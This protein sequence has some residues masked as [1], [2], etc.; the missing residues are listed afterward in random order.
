MA[1]LPPAVSERGQTAAHAKPAPASPACAGL[2]RPRP[3]RLPAKPT[4]ICTAG[5]TDSNY[6]AMRMDEEFGIPAPPG[7]SDGIIEL[8]GRGRIS[9]RQVPGPDGAPTLVLL[10]GLAAT[11]RLNWF[12][13]LPALSERY[14]VIVVDHRGHGGG[15]RTRRFRLA[16]CADDVAALADVLEVE[17]YFAVGYSMGG[18]IAKLCW[19][20]HPDRVR[21]LVLCAT[22]R[23]FVWPEARAAASAVMPGMVLAARVAPKTFQRRMMGNVLAGLPRGDR[24]ERVRAELQG[25]DPATVLQAARAVMRFT[26]HDWCSA[27][28]IPT[29]V[30]VTTRDRIVPTSRQYKLASAIRGA[31]VFEVDGDHMACVNAANRFVPALVEACNHVVGQAAGRPVS[32]SSQ[33]SSVRASRRKRA[34]L[35]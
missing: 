5:R 11:G 34:G 24:R 10:H 14:N 1:G 18:P 7:C 32:L 31:R 28:N 19:S 4:V 15:I 29:A 33:T 16:D 23:H 21:G 2:R 22:A 9:V 13:A 25:S 8:P 3:A 30:V 6:D 12:T 26:S 20:R 27:I 17:N 35:L